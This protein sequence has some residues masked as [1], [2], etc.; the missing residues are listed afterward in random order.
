MGS[1]RLGHKGSDLAHTRTHSLSN[2]VVSVPKNLGFENFEIE[3]IKT[4]KTLGLKTNVPLIILY[5]KCIGPDKFFRLAL[6]VS[7]G[8]QPYT[9]LLLITDAIL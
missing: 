1:Q 3:D 4:L 2:N 8:L 9:W 6:M 5:N 7:L